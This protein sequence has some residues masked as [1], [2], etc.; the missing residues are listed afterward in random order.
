[1]TRD[2]RRL[3]N[4]S[5]DQVAAMVLELGSQLHLERQRRMALENLLVR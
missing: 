1:M 2:H 5:I 4:A 3:S